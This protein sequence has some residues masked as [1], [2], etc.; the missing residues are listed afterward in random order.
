MNQMLFRLS[1][2]VDQLLS[3]IKILGYQQMAKY[4][5]LRIC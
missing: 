2:L 5:T 1:E 3:G 4:H